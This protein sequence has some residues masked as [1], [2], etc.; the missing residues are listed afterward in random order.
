M[1]LLK[2]CCSKWVNESRDYRELSV[3]QEEGAEI[4]VLAKGDIGDKPARDTVEDF[5]V[6][7]YTTKPL[8]EKIPSPIN[9]LVSLFQWASFARKQRPDIISGH[10]LL[11]LT[12]GWLSTFF[13]RKKPK[14]IYDSHEFEIG[15]NADR[16]GFSKWLILHWEHFMIKRSALTVVVNDS[17][18]DEI[19]KLYKLKE[20]PAVVR[21][22][23]MGFDINKTECEK[24]RERLLEKLGVEKLLIYHGLVCK[25]RGIEATIGAMPKLE[26][27][28]LLVVGN[29]D[30]SEYI[31][32][33]RKMSNELNVDTRV[34]FHEAVPHEELWKFVGAADVGVV[35][36]SPVSK[37]YY[38]ALPNK[39]FECIQSGTPVVGS[40][41]PEIK[42]IV[43]GHKV[44]TI[45]KPDDSDS[46]AAAVKELINSESMYDEVKSNV[47]NSKKTLSWESEKIALSKAFNEISHEL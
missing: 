41:L 38:Y 7:R 34:E 28:G 13:T 11:A 3:Y 15:R 8:G 5:K 31:D 20:R 42:R 37:S 14:L 45:A 29:P 2:I 43:N 39:L 6:F 10:D 46:I 4:T 44:G 22:I 17:I 26:N 16:Y 35:M 27:V 47:E 1:K 40:D 30:S 21:N 36:I 19:A 25:G 12:I 32:K 23:P 9:K 18:A 33:L 24:V